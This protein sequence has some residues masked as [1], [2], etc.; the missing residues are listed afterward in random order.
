[1]NFNSHFHVISTDGC[2][3]E[4]GAFTVNPALRPKDLENLF[5]DEI[6]K[7]L[8]SEGK[9]NNRVIENMLTWRHIGFNVY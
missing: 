8:K 6:L 2:F 9:I 1:M 5:R 7:M 3:T 4:S